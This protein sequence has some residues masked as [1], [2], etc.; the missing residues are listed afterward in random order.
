[1]VLVSWVNGHHARP[2]TMLV[3]SHHARS[4]GF[5]VDKL[6]IHECDSVPV[7]HCLG[8]QVKYCHE[9]RYLVLVHSSV[10]N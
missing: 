3:R 8:V 1:M 7:G 6:G 9:W 4:L 2:E 5:Q 10:C